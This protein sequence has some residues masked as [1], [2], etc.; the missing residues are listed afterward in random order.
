MDTGFPPAS[1]DLLGT[2]KW[3][4]GLSALGVYMGPQWKIDAL[5]QHY[6][7]FAGDDDRDDV[8]LTNRQLFFITTA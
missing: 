3:L 8:N 2:G 4:A 1:E 5:V 7:N 6:W